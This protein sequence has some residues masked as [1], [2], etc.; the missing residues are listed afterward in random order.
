MVT[1]KSTLE[2]WGGV[3]FGERLGLEMMTAVLWPLNFDQ[4]ITVIINLLAL[5]IENEDQID[6]ISDMLKKMLKL[7]QQHEPQG[8]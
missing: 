6:A 7:S 3:S 4:R 1:M 5:Q 2:P 8:R